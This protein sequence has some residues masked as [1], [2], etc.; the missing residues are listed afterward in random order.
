MVEMRWCHHTNS[1]T[2]DL[3]THCHWPERPGA[4]DG[5]PP[6]S[7]RFSA[8]VV[9]PFGH[10]SDGPPTQFV[11]IAT[12]ALVDW[13]RHGSRRRGIGNDGPAA[14]VPGERP[15]RADL[16]DAAGPHRGDRSQPARHPGLRAV[17]RLAAAGRGLRRHLGSRPRPRQR[18]RRA[19]KRHRRSRVAGYRSRSSAASR[20]WAARSRSKRIATTRSSPC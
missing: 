15:A 7:T 17:P 12:L 4:R 20:F 13:R 2:F 5:G 6:C 8:M 16:H 9:T 10:S 3:C 19:G 18:R 11:V 14:A 1:T